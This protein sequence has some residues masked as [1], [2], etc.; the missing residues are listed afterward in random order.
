MD[1]ISNKPIYAIEERTFQFAKHI[2]I[3]INSLPKTIAALK[4]G[5]NWLGHLEQLGQIVLKQVNNSLAKKIF[6]DTTELKN[7]F[8]AIVNK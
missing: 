3:W 2:R 8:S 6:Q 4:M 5:N 1:A 7:I